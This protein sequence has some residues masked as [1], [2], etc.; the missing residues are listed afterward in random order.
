MTQR[1]PW[2]REVRGKGRKG[3][4]EEFTLTSID[5]LF[6][7]KWGKTSASRCCQGSVTLQNFAP[8]AAA[9]APRWPSLLLLCHRK[10]SP[11]VI[12]W[13]HRQKLHFGIN[14]M[15]D[16]GVMSPQWNT[17]A[18]TTREG[19]I[20]NVPAKVFFFTLSLG[21]WQSLILFSPFWAHLNKQFS[22]FVTVQ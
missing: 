11:A 7:Q 3:E 1:Q 18:R 19:T 15:L 21:S 17:S 6:H 12:Q 4:R 5:T 14:T 10:D 20:P 2:E 16:S 22:F 13:L 8:L 9:A